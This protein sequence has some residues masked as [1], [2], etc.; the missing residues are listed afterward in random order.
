MLIEKIYKEVY[1]KMQ[2]DTQED[3]FTM[4]DKLGVLVEE[5]RL[6]ELDKEKLGLLL[7][8]ACVIGQERGFVS[9]WKFL[10]RVL[11]ETC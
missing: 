11:L 4:S 10:M 9:G 5:T 2:E 6:E 8:K 7:C 3:D 1:T